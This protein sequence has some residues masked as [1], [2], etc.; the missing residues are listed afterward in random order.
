MSSSS[1][2]L[3]ERDRVLSPSSGSAPRQ[4]LQM[5]LISLPIWQWIMNGMLLLFAAGCCPSELQ[6]DLILVRQK[7]LLPFLAFCSSGTTAAV[8]DGESV[9]DPDPDRDHE[10]VT[11]PPKP[12]MFKLHCRAGPSRPLLW[13][14]GA[15]QLV[16]SSV[17]YQQVSH[18]HRH[19][20]GHIL[21][22]KSILTELCL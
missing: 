20:S 7:A 10:H 3:P 2:S 8:R 5:C 22:N 17:H 11:S 16:C 15:F 12:A 4:L 13:W 14:R 9:A 18:H 1:S 21:Q 19:I 6:R